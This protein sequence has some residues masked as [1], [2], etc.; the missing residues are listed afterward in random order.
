MVALRRTATIT[1]ATFTAHGLRLNLKPGK[2]E[3]VIQ[4][5]GKG[6]GDILYDLHVTNDGWVRCDGGL[7]LHVT[8]VYVHLGGNI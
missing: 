2:T 8:R 5:R 4:L 3:A 7:Q 1:C 6:V